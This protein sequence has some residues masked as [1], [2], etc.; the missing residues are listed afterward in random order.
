MI[1]MMT[2]GLF[3]LVVISL[4]FALIALVWLSLISKQLSVLG[5]RMLESEDT[6]RIIEAADKTVS[7]GSRITDCES[8]A[9]ESQNQLMEHATRLN[10]VSTKLEAAEQML[11]SHAANIAKVSEKRASSELRF[12][13]LINNISEKLNNLLELDTKVDNLATNLKSVE[14]SVNN[15]RAGIAAADQSVNALKNK[16]ETLEKF[17]TVVE[18]THSIIQ[19]AFADIR[20]STIHEEDLG[21]SSEANQEEI[22]QTSESEQ[23]EAVD[24]EMP[25]TGMYRYP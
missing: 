10:E 9:D 3:V 19:A 2:I 15:N 5:K 4:A 21:E 18:K 13:E 23:E 6:E 25:E 24:N 11:D 7:F 1:D 8:K 14:G 16:I 20:A 17:Q 12:D 22:F